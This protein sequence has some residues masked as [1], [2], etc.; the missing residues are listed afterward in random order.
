MKKSLFIVLFALCS[1]LVSA[2]NSKL[3]GKI[4]DKVSGESISY[5]NAVLISVSDSSYLKGAITNDNGVFLIENIKA[6]TYNLEL[7][8]IGNQSVQ[9]K[10]ILLQRGTRDIGEVALNM[11]SENLNEVTIKATKSAISYK[12]DKKVIDAGSFPGASVAMDLL[13]NVPSL[14]VNFEGK[15]SYR[16]DGIFKVFI[17]GQS[18]A[19]GEEKLRQLSADKIDKIEVITNPSAKYD[20]EGTAGIIQVILKK[21]RLQGYAINTSV[22]A[23]SIGAYDWSFSVDEKGE[24]GGWHINGH[25][26]NRVWWK[27]T[28]NEKQIFRNA[29]NTQIT[30]AKNKKKNNGESSF[31]EFGFN[32]DLTNKDYINFSINTNPIRRKD[33]NSSVGNIIEQDY[34][35]SSLEKEESYFLNSRGS[36]TYQ[37]LGTS[38]NYSHAFNKDRSHLLSAN[39]AYSAYLIPFDEQ[40]LDEKR[41]A[42]FT[43][44]IGYRGKEHNEIIFKADILYKNKLSEHSSFE[45]G[46]KIDLD[47]IPKITSISGV[48][49][50]EDNI[51]PF[52]DEPMNQEVDFVQDIYAS[53]LT[54]KSSFNKF[55]YQLGLRAELTDRI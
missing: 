2:Q 44:R 17:N 22:S 11:L 40:K 12:V 5:A 45:A 15:L 9:M 32:Y 49:D 46:A 36:N 28:V 52:P 39:F 34:N 42:T 27:A 19:N 1:Q 54:F 23:S 26:A 6:G 4:I 3:T 13:E 29:D 24:K 20:S 21:N 25:L 47:H 18:V 33:K 51:T 48:F 8:F 43:E 38:L 41:Y 37:Y 10:H 55:E 50:D 53:F 7:S 35:L 14:Q 31:L 30:E 16:G